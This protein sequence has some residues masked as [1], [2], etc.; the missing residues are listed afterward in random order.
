MKNKN[1][2]YTDLEEIRNWDKEELVDLLIYLAHEVPND[3]TFGA[4]VRQELLK[5]DKR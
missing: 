3:Q 1:E 5:F 2:V 4:V